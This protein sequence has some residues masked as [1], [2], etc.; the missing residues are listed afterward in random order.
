[1]ETDGLVLM[2]AFPG[3]VA[4]TFLAELA[5]PTDPSWLSFL[6]ELADP[7]DPFL[8]E[9]PSLTCVRD[10]VV[11]LASKDL[12]AR[13]QELKCKRNFDASEY[14]HK[15]EQLLVKLK[16]MMPGSTTGVTALED[17]ISHQ[18]ASD[19]ED[20]ARILTEHW[21]RVLTGRPV[22]CLSGSAI[23]RISFNQLMLL[24]GR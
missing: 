13:L 14:C 2:M 1:M 24:L 18:V 12:A 8:R 9:Q 19:P 5:D 11:E 3:D 15:K 4:T 7:T 10:H 22:D 6:A 16:R 21:G 23:C 20:M 17:P